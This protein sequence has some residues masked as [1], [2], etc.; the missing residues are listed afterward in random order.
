MAAKIDATSRGVS[1]HSEDVAVKDPSL[2]KVERLVEEIFLSIIQKMKVLGLSE[3]QASEIIFSKKS[4]IE[5]QKS[6]PKTSLMAIPGFN[7]LS[8][9][10]SSHLQLLINEHPGNSVFFLYYVLFARVY[11]QIETIEKLEPGNQAFHQHSKELIFV[12]WLFFQYC[13][14]KFD[15]DHLVKNN[16][17]RALDFMVLPT[18]L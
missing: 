1:F 17:S 3:T 6:C 15:V 10:L 9:E 11:R 14:T 12:L 4:S 8:K 2:D 5:I 18:F 13:D 7:T 16:P